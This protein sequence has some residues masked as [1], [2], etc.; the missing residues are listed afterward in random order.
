[1]SYSIIISKIFNKFAIF[2]WGVTIL[3][4]IMA[5]VLY[6]QL[7]KEVPDHI[8]A[9]GAADSYGGKLTVFIL[10]FALAMIGLLVSSKWID[11]RYADLTIQNTLTKTL[12]LV[13]MILLWYGAGI[14]FLTYYQLTK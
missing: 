9:F 13:I 12:M 8:N 5:I 14:F 10:P 2:N 1:M 3:S 4:F 6:P 11:N 7:P